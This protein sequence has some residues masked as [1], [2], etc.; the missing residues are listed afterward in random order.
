MGLVIFYT[1]LAWVRRLSIFKSGFTISIAMIIFTTLLV[2]FY[3]I[4]GLV[5]HGPQNDGFKIINT[6]KFTDMIGF[7]FY[8][9]EGIGT[10][11]PIMKES[12]NR[13]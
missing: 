2:M 5:K 6:S 10:I 3:A 9:F 7:S 4:I 11:M 12:K 8:S 13:H 1:P